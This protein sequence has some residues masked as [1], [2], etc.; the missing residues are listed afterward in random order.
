MRLNEFFDKY[1]VFTLSELDRFLSQRGSSNR[2]TR[3]SLLSYYRQRNRIISV[4][5]GL[6]AVVPAGAS[7][8]TF[9]VDP[10]L[11]VSKMK[12]DAVL[13]YHTALEFHGKAYSVFRRFFYLT[14][15]A[16]IPVQ[17]RDY[18]FQCVL[19]P[20]ALK[21][22]NKANFDVQNAERAGIE[23]KVTGLERTFVDVLDRPDIS[24]SWEEI[25]RSLESIEFFDI[26]KVI[27][28]AILL[29]NSTTAAKAGFFLEQHRK[30][31]MIESKHLGPLFDLKPRQP[32]YLERRKRKAGCFIS[33]WNLVVPRELVD[34]S[35]KDVL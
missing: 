9:A 5:R 7:P 23:V 17:F 18:E 34:R 35:W 4:R 14:D 10:F 19:I 6:Y 13:A 15:K 20:K 27:E 2:S 29:G 21:K 24:G 16:S 11:L 32:H 30:E 8:Q 26:D 12:P 33:N 25:W 28:Y 22:E 1:P 31:L 3:N